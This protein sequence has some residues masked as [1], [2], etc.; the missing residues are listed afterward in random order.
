MLPLPRCPL[1]RPDVRVEMPLN[2][3]GGQGLALCREF[4]YTLWLARGLIREHGAVTDPNGTF[5]PGPAAKD[6]TGM[7]TFE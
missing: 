6:S 1:A 4:V 5:V 2:Q 7:G 3:P